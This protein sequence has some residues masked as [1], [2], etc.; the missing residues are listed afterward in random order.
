MKEGFRYFKT[1]K[2]LVLS[3]KQTYHVIHFQMF[4]EKK[5]F[6]EMIDEIKTEINDAAG[7]FWEDKE[8][9]WICRECFLELVDS[10][11]EKYLR[12]EEESKVGHLKKEVQDK[13]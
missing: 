3:D 10:K 7:F 8:K 1:L 13:L 4:L 5:T 6:R 12:S 9:V 11:I 2:T